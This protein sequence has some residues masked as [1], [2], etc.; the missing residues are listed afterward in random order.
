MYRGKG[1]AGELVCQRAK[2]LRGQ[3]LDKVRVLELV[4]LT[5]FRVF[6]YDV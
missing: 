5:S 3:S 4:T 2:V 1:Y 6:M